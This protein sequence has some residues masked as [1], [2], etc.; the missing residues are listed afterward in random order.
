M[1]TNTAISGTTDL[2]F[3]AASYIQANV[4][5]LV[6]ASYNNG[7]KRFYINGVLLGTQTVTGGFTTNANGMSIGA[8]GGFT[9]STGR[10]YYYSGDIATMKFYNRVLTD[11]EVSQ[12][13]QATK[14]RFGL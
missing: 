11:A 7:L 1:R 10:S 3:T 5:F 9:A 8:Y 12:N 2:Q 6:T 4:W 13:Y 14:S